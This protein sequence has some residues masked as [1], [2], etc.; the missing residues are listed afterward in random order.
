[1]SARA[2]TCDAWET[3]H[4]DEGRVE[5]IRKDGE[6]VAGLCTVSLDRESAQHLAAFIREAKS[7]VAR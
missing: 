4:A 1:M 6:I 3:I 7:G 2:R 5:V